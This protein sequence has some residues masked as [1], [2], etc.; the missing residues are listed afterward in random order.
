MGQPLWLNWGRPCWESY[1]ENLPDH[2]YLLRD[3]RDL[4]LLENKYAVP[5]RTAPLWE[6]QKYQI[7][8]TRRISGFPAELPRSCWR[9][10]RAVQRPHEELALVG[11]ATEAAQA[12][13]G[14]P[15]IVKAAPAPFE[16]SGLP[17]RREMSQLFG[18]LKAALSLLELQDVTPRK[19]RE[20]RERGEKLKEGSP[21]HRLQMG[22]KHK[23]PFVQGPVSLS[24]SDEII[25]TCFRKNSGVPSL[26]EAI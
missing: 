12:G 15:V 7:I 26:K 8:S 16:E 1:R 18:L 19:R 11:L 24:Y 6:L 5:G 21:F 20:R 3:F 23:G 9:G 10:R 2:I 4:P 13:S 25:L 14:V 22:G 17:S